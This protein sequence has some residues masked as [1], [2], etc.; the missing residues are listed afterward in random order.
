MEN[1]IS[2]L[3][4]E[5][6][7]LL[8]RLLFQDIMDFLNEIHI[9]LNLNQPRADHVKH[10]PVHTRCQAQGGWRILQRK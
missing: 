9:R 5:I 10:I 1:L 2:K 8:I 6:E 7:F 4:C 3:F